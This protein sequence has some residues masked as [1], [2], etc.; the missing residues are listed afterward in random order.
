MTY[1]QYKEK[2]IKKEFEI[3]RV[4]RYNYIEKGR[5]YKPLTKEKIKEFQN[6][7][8]E[9][10]KLFTKD[11]KEVL[12]EYTQGGYIPINRDLATDTKNSSEESLNNAINKFNL[13]EDITY[14]G[15][16]AKYY[17]EYN[18]GDIIDSKIFY[19]T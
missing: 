15:T 19:S 2:F 6:Q 10:Y 8:N 16:C 14:R 5:D 3:D 18:V 11:E 9:V 4:K 12:S 7:S 1:K 13:N 17:K